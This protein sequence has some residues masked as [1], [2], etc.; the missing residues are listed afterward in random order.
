MHFPATARRVAWRLA[1]IGLWANMEIY[2][3][4]KTTFREILE[5]MRI[6]KVPLFSVSCP[7]GVARIGLWA[8]IEIYGHLEKPFEKY[9]KT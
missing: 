6:C 5:N 7:N 9:L 2:G 3:H 1:Q 8:Q 4:L